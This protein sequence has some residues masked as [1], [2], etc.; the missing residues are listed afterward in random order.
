MAPRPELGERLRHLRLLRG[1]SI[2]ECATQTRVAARHIEALERGES[3]PASLRRLAR[4]FGIDSDAFLAGRVVGEQVIEGVPGATVFLRHGAFQDFDASDSAV[5]DRAMRIARAATARQGATTTS[6][7]GH[8]FFEPVSVAGPRRRDAAQQGYRLA[9]HVRA[10]LGFDLEPVGD[11]V[12]ILEAR[13]GIAVVVDTLRSRGLRASAVVDEGGCAAAV[14]LAAPWGDTAP[15]DVASRVNLAHELCHVLFDPIAPNT[16]RI[17]LDDKRGGFTAVSR[18]E[19]RAN[20]FAAEFLMPI[21]GVRALLGAETR[22]VLAPTTANQLVLKVC[23][24]FATSWP[25]TVYHLR[26]HGVIAD[27]AMAHLLTHRPERSTSTL[28]LPGVGSGSLRFGR[29][30][31]HEDEALRVAVTARASSQVPWSEGA[32]VSLGTDPHADAWYSLLDEEVSPLARTEAL[33]A[34][35][36]EGDPALAAWLA[37]EL[38]I[39]DHPAP[40]LDALVFAAERT[41]FEDPA[42]RERVISALYRIAQSLK[43]TERDAPLWSAIRRYASMVPVASAD[44]LLVF[45]N[46]DERTTTLQ[47]ALQGISR[48]FETAP[49]DCETARVRLRAR[50]HALAAERIKPARVHGSEDA[51][52]CFACFEAA[53]HLEDPEVDEVHR[54]LE[55]LG[56]ERMTARARAL[57]EA[58]RASRQGAARA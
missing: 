38:D 2:A 41:A 4:C 40:W 3:D 44:T 50:V 36:A 12:A 6:L 57:R 9:R 5:L 54:W 26:N 34:L 49:R 46:R 55:S 31:T 48:I 1:W 53:L 35:V 11:L 33:N 7:A 13:F 47:V 18:E 52:L 25:L 27:E 23:E 16:V 45:L 24:H 14:V 56:R 30:P 42:L 22:N 28:R 10:W 15:R 32:V 21:R 51:A 58:F 19:S 43:A 20:G 8:R 29:A 39:E 17:D 37:D